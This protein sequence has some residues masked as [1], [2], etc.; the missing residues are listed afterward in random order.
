VIAA[1]RRWV[2][3]RST[4]PTGYA[5]PILR[6]SSGENWSAFLELIMPGYFTMPDGRRFDIPELTA[7]DLRQIFTP[8][9]VELGYVVFSWNQLHDNLASLF[10]V[11]FTPLQDRS[12]ALN[13]SFYRMALD[14]WHSTN[15]DYIQRAMLREALRQATIT[16]EQREAIESALNEID[17]SLRHKRNAAIHSPLMFTTA[18][19]EDAVKT[20]IEPSIW[21]V[22]PNAKAMRK[23]LEKRS[24]E[25][26]FSRQE[27]IEELKWYGALADSLGRYIGAIRLNLGNPEIDALPDKLVL[28]QPPPVKSRKG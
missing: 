17:N 19:I 24:T 23:S 2:S 6:A 7:E 5:Q 22:S 9:G 12:A 10:G 11:I 25:A 15:N 21:S 20:F 8:Y 26:I 14:V 13:S 18:V 28:P 27:L 4:H 1:A 3:L 16:P